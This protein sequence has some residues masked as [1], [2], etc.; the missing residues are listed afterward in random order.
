MRHVKFIARTVLVQN[1]DP[2][3]AF[4]MVN[5]ILG[6]EGLLDQYRRTRYF[7][8]PTYMRRRINY[9]RCKGVYNEDMDRKIKFV[10]RTNREDPYPGC[11]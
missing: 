1:N 9:E 10:M 7:E 4:R 3:A 6:A 8:Q 11:H 2:E 5:R